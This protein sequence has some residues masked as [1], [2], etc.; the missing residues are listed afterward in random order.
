MLEFGAQCVYTPMDDFC[1]KFNITNEWNKI[2]LPAFKSYLEKIGV[3]HT[4]IDLNG[5]HGSLQK[6]ITGDLKYLGKFDIL[7]NF[8]SSEHVAPLSTQYKCFKNFHQLCKVGGYMI[9]YV[10]PVGKWINHA[11]AHYYNDF[12]IQLG[13]ANN[14]K[15]I[16]YEEMDVSN[17]ISI[18]FQK[19]ED[20]TFME[21]KDFPL[22]YIKW[23]NNNLYKG[24]YDKK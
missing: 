5:K 18:I 23:K 24:N 11:P 21:E 13:K 8:G 2:K 3:S 20:N 14:Y 10:P 1:L 19:Q 4:S 17:L 9:H 22:K 12:F 16:Y 6:D 7:T 15:T